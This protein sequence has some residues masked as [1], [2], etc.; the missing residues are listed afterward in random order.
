MRKFKREDLMQFGFL[1]KKNHPPYGLAQAVRDYLE[2]STKR[3][4]QLWSYNETLILLAARDKQG[5]RG[6]KTTEGMFTCMKLFHEMARTLD[7]DS[8][9]RLFMIKNGS[10]CYSFISYCL[11][12]KKI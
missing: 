11:G 1:M 4:N 8:M 2:I 7:E 12:G 9:L 3:N 10:H 5:F 6:F